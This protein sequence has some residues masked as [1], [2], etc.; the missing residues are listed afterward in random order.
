MNVDKVVYT[1]PVGRCDSDR[2]LICVEDW[3]DPAPRGTK[4]VLM[5]D[6]IV[7]GIQIMI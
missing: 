5:T 4:S 7:A 1:D 2:I 3:I 6:K